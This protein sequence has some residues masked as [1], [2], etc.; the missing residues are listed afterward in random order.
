MVID[1]SK[2][3]IRPETLSEHEEVNELIYRSFKEAYGIEV[4]KFMKEHFSRE[5]E[6]E[7]FIPELSLVAVLEKGKIVGEVALHKTDIT[8]NRE[9][10]TQ[11]VLAQ[12]AV[13]PEYMMKEAYL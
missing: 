4:G 11:L 9:K 5:S 7:T 2:V 12:S 1:K 13:L 8:T 6:K 10:I 3:I